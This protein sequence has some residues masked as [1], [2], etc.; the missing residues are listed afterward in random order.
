MK[1]KKK[2]EEK[3]DILILLVISHIPQNPCVVLD[4]AC[5]AAAKWN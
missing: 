4:G 5:L 2:K 3:R 1:Q